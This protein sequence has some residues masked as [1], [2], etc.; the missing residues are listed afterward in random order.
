[1]NIQRFHICG[2]LCL[3]SSL[4]I[5]SAHAAPKTAQEWM[6]HGEKSLAKSLFSSPEDR[7]N[8]ASGDFEH[9]A[10][11]FKAAGEW[12][13]AGD[14]Y[15]RKSEMSKNL[16]QVQSSAEDLK[17]AGSMYRKA[18]SAKAKECFANAV[19]LLG[20]V[21]KYWEAARLCEKIGEFETTDS[22]EWYLKAAVY[23]NKDNKPAS[24]A[25]ALELAAKG[26][27]RDERY[28]QA[29]ELFQS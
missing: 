29:Q 3:F 27:L 6:N 1:M 13:Q 4:F 12:E 7:Y 16:Q 15:V 21:Q 2:L 11:L 18:K 9:A 25:S 10:T 22:E 23:F 5:Y 24:A 26:Y 14:A 19:D 17:N 8:K 20:Q 28:A